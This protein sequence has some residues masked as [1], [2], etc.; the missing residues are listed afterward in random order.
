MGPNC[1]QI[2]IEADSGRG[3]VMPA[4]IGQRAGE[5]KGAKCRD[6]EILDETNCEG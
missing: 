3:S 4:G 2:Q 5:A 6:L 1:S